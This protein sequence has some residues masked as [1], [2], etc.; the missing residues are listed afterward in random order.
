MVKPL[1]RKLLGVLFLEGRMLLV[2]C[3]YILYLGGIYASAGYINKLCAMLG[4]LA[5]I[6]L[7]HENKKK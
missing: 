5:N 3:I 4:R 2:P 1:R 7:L 6:K